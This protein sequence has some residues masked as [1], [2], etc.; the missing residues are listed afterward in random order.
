MGKVYLATDPKLGRDV[1]VKLLNAAAADDATRD[2]FRLEARAIAALKHPNIVELYDFSGVGADDLFL[3]M[4]YVPGRSLYDLVAERG[5]LGEVTALCIVH[6]LVLAVGHAH[7]HN[8]VHRDI[9]PENV[10]LYNGRVVLTDFGIVKQVAAEGALGR[11]QQRSMTEALG[12]PGFMAPE[13][14]TSQPLTAQTDIFGVGVVL[15]NL[16][17]GRLPFPNTSLGVL[18][19]AV[20]KGVYED[21]RD[22]DPLLSDGLCAVVARCLEPKPK[23]RY[24]S[25]VEL[26]EAILSVLRTHG[27]A[28]VR[29]EIRKYEENPAKQAVEQR[30]RSLDVLLRD[31]KI[32]IKDKNEPR[33]QAIIQRM[34]TI[35]PLGQE[36]RNVTGIHW[37]GK[38]RARLAHQK[39]VQGSS[40]GLGV[41]F[42]SGGVLGGALALFGLVAGLIPTWVVALFEMLADLVGLGF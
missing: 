17:T 8:V 36:V 22:F 35:A 23:N 14:L 7:Q 11:R 32:A 6:E 24:D 41:A 29:S 28:E 40:V 4:E 19:K 3:V 2:R 15:Y 9:K 16:A 39:A 30:E 18:I 27:V 20:K 31:L 25:T 37:V 42:V 34:Q 5:P 38:S 12:T 26:R 33:L 1:A 21:P 13:Q 10:L